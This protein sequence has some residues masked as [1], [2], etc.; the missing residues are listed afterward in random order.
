MTGRFTAVR[1][2]LDDCPSFGGVNETSVLPSS[3]YGIVLFLDWSIAHLPLPYQMMHTAWR[4][5]LNML[6]SS[7]Q[8][9]VIDAEP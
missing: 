4:I 5:H 7:S 1:L 2:L 6:T 8:E 3:G 9:E